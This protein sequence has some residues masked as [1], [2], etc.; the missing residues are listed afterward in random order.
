M[1]SGS[2]LFW[3]K[4]LF[5]RYQYH[6]LKYTGPNS[7]WTVCLRVC[8]VCFHIIFLQLAEIKIMESLKL[9]WPYHS[10][11]YQF[12]LKSQWCRRKGFHQFRKKFKFIESFQ[13]LARFHKDL[14]IIDVTGVLGLGPLLHCSKK[15]SCFLYFCSWCRNRLIYFG[16]Q[17]VVMVSI[18]SLIIHKIWNISETIVLNKLNWLMVV[19]CDYRCR[20]VWDDGWDVFP[21]LGMCF[22]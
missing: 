21:V 8:W 9:K 11:V 15:V 4:S 10:N 18:W 20:N 13:P 17:L 3:W 19:L 6:H 16:N 1:I 5:L 7:S 2:I 12:E 22:G 14:S